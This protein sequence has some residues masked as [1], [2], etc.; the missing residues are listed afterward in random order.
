VLFVEKRDS[1]TE[2][3][4]GC[5]RSR[6]AILYVVLSGSAWF[7]SRI[8]PWRFLQHLRPRASCRGSA[9]H[10]GIPAAYSS[11]PPGMTP[12]PKPRTA[13]CYGLQLAIARE[14][15]SRRRGGGRAWFRS[16]AATAREGKQR[17]GAR[18]CADGERGWR[19]MENGAFVAPRPACQHPGRYRQIYTRN[20]DYYAVI[21]G[22]PTSRICG[23]MRG[24]GDGLPSSQLASGPLAP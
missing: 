24:C 22:R 21:P 11:R 3:L 5:C 12:D 17:R 6:F 4:P 8:I 2:L 10:C 20:T 15:G 14:A 9:S 23:P 19:E 18:C 1:Y 7:L 16:L 13:I